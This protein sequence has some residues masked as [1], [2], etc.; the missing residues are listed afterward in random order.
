MIASGGSSS[1]VQWGQR[2]TSSSSTTDTLML[3]D[4]SS[5][6]FLFGSGGGGELAATGFASGFP[7]L[8]GFPGLFFAGGFGSFTTKICWQNL[9]L[10]F[11][12]K[13]VGGIFSDFSHSGHCI[14]TGDAIIELL[15]ADQF[16]EG[17]N[18][19]EWGSIP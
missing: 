5:Q 3:S 8:T 15:D 14:S 7:G 2:A 10:I 9:H 12:P 1:M 18:S 13:T 16:W 11:L 4:S 6:R 17:H 19:D